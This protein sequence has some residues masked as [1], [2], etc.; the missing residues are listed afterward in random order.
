MRIDWYATWPF[1]VRSWPWPEVKFST[2]PFKV[3]WSSDLSRASDSSFDASW[4]EEHDAGK[5]KFVQ[6]LGQKLL[7]KNGF[8]K[9]IGYFF[10]FCPL[11]AK[12]L[13]VGQI[14]ENYSERALMRLSNALFRG[15][16][17]LLVSELCVDLL[18]IFGSWPTNRWILTF[19]DLWWPDLW[20]DQRRDRND[21]FLIFLRLRRLFWTKTIQNALKHR[22]RSRNDSLSR[23]I[24]TDNPSSCH[25]GHFRS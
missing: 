14:W 18:T 15:A 17:A 19:N 4:R 6:G 3:K 23:N 10:R 12:P 7:Q 2:W 22:V 20:P 11:E 5:R 16:V 21:F 9:K 8:R 13:T 1:R 24:A 25:Q